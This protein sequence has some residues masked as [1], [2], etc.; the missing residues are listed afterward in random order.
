MVRVT[1]N[2][3]CKIIKQNLIQK[4]Q[5]LIKITLK[6]KD[7]LAF[8]LSISFYLEIREQSKLKLEHNVGK[9]TGMFD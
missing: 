2:R 8:L 7:Q 4:M 5:K 1:T 3:F 6:K 9:V